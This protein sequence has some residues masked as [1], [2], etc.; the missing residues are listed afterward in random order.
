MRGTTI[1]DALTAQRIEAFQSTCPLRGTTI[2]LRRVYAEKW[3]SIHMPLAGH[4]VI[5]GIWISEY[6]ISI[7]MPLAGHDMMG[8]IYGGD[9]KISIHMPLAGHD[10]KKA[11]RL[12][13]I[14]VK[15]G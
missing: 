5:Y 7:H 11:Q 3:I 14:F 4:D 13:C 9:E 8:A 2:S 15:T 6:A 1:L 12:L 10:G